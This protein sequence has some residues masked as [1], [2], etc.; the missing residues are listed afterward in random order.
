MCATLIY[1]IMLSCYIFTGTTVS[2][3]SQ[4]AIQLVAWRKW[5][6]MLSSWPL[7]TS[8]YLGLLLILRRHLG[9][10]RSAT[11]IRYFTA[12]PVQR[13]RKGTATQLSLLEGMEIWKWEWL[14]TF[15][16][17]CCW[18]MLIHTTLLLCNN[19]TPIQKRTSW[20][21]LMWPPWIKNS[22]TTWS[23][24]GIQGLLNLL[25]VELHQKPFPIYVYLLVNDAYMYHICVTACLTKSSIIA[26]LNKETL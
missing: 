22:D 2:L 18:K 6:L 24:F 11:R 1:T 5:H 25:P 3:F 19:F 17:C 9:S 14:S 23:L 20:Q 21:E 15:W 10:K 13:W 12:N 16:K 4:D 26:H 8:L 7:S